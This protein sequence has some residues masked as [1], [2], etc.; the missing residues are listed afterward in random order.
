MSFE[1]YSFVEPKTC[2]AV[3]LSWTKRVV[4]P[5]LVSF[6]VPPICGFRSGLSNRF[7]N[8][9]ATFIQ[10]YNFGLYSELS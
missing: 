3:W 1:F 9:D 8:C 4:N 5:H 10:N 7:R 2:L 6:A